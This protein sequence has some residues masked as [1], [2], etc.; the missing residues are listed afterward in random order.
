MGSHES[1]QVLTLLKELS[2]LKELGSGYD[3]DPKNESEPDAHQQ[4]R[5]EIAEEIKALA[6]QKKSHAEQTR[7]AVA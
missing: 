5:Q 2:M 6:D 1:E 4:R 7:Q 3:T